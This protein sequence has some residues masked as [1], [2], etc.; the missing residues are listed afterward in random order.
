MSQDSK[1]INKKVGTSVDIKPGGHCKS[2]GVIYGII[3]KKCEEWYVG[4]TGKTMSERYAK[5]KSDIKLRPNNCDLAKHCSMTPHNIEDLEVSIIDHGIVNM[6]ER[7]RIED[8]FIC[9][10]QT[11]KGS[12]IN[13]DLGAYAKEMYASYA[14][15]LENRRH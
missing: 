4:E 15:C 7:R 13:C 6:D 10:L 11:L 8:K 2:V 3:C 14:A 12:G 1:V 5:H 9:K